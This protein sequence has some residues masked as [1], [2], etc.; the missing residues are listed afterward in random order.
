MESDRVLNVSSTPVV[1]RFSNRE[2]NV[3]V[4]DHVLDLSPHCKEF[5]S[6]LC[7]LSVGSRNLLVKE[8]RMMKYTTSTG[9]KT[10]T[11]NTLNQVQKKAM[12][13]ALVA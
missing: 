7:R 2:W 9:Q 10:G 4:F 12:A 13:V 5:V 6:V 3:A 1:S 8:K 11:S